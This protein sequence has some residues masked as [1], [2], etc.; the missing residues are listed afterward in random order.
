MVKKTLFTSSGHVFPLLSFGSEI[1]P[2]IRI[3]TPDDCGD[4]MRLKLTM[5]IV[6]VST[7][8]AITLDAK[9]NTKLYPIVSYIDN[10]TGGTVKPEDLR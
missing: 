2:D 9:S 5:A 6:V 1:A 4:M 7:G 10:D 8:T 3:R